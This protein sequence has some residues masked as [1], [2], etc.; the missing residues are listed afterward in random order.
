MC[1]QV[2][3]HPHI[4][5]REWG[6]EAITYLVQ[7]AF[8]YHHNNPVHVT[9]VRSDI[10]LSYTSY[11]F[12]LWRQ[13]K[14]FHPRGG[15][16]LRMISRRQAI[17]NNRAGEMASERHWYL[18][19]LQLLCHDIKPRLEAAKTLEGTVQF[20]LLSAYIYLK[21]KSA[22]DPRPLSGGEHYRAHSLFGFRR[23]RCDLPIIPL[24]MRRILPGNIKWR[25]NLGPGAVT[26][27][28]V[29]GVVCGTA[30]RRA[31][32][33]IGMRRAAAALARRPIRRR[34]AAHD[35]DHIRHINAP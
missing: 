25:W 20:F 9:E 23:S 19:L 12:F 6:V 17:S 2:C 10:S 34:L 27:G 7:A 16:P 21:T 5:M 1:I 33:P 35:G 8:Q 28:A 32:A 24:S 14:S 18:S 11:A 30:L 29:V 4:R 26:V 22:P 15:F 31:R 13:P 3:Q